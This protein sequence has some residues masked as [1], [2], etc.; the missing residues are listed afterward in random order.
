VADSLF[1]F[2]SLQSKVPFLLI[3]EGMIDIPKDAEYVFYVN[4]YDAAQ[5]S[6]GGKNLFKIDD[7]KINLPSHM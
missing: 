7:A 1:K 3:I 5:L 6:L 4:G 2:N